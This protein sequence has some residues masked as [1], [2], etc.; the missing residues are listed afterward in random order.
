M[1][2]I[3]V[4]CP[5]CNGRRFVEGLLCERCDGNGRVAVIRDDRTPRELARRN[6]AIAVVILGA[7]LGAII[8]IDW[9]LILAALLK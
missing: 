9:M 6:L 1:N 4:I 5:A 8:A 2:A 3:A 7:I